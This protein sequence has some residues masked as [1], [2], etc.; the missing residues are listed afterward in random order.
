MKNDR[1][2]REQLATTILARWYGLQDV[3]WAIWAAWA[4][5][6]EIAE[7]ARDRANGMW[8]PPSAEV[9]RRS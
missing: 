8:A 5:R 2:S 1:R 6:T 9:E 3:E 7:L 4:T